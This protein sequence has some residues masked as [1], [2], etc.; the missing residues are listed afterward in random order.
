M[1]VSSG[2]YDDAVTATYSQNDQAVGRLHAE[3]PTL[4]AVLGDVTG[5][6]GLD[7]ACGTGFYTRLLSRCGA[8]HVVGVDASPAM[9]ESARTMTAPDERIEYRVHDVAT[10]PDIGTFDIVT[11]GFLLNYA[12]TRRQLGDMCADIAARLRPGGRFVGSL[13]MSTYDWRRPLAA[14]YGVTFDYSHDMSDGENFTFT[15]H[16]SPPLTLVNCYWRNETYQAALED[17]GLVNVRM[18]PWQ[19]SAEAI[20]RF[21]LDFWKPWLANPTH[22]VISAVQP[23]RSEL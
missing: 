6:H 18:T 17:A 20:N 22:M 14:R 3:L 12:Q 2:Q 13:P 23:I 8:D 4:L 5:R 19:P 11:A 1:S 16:F 9:I 7:L 10:L 15:L 21:G